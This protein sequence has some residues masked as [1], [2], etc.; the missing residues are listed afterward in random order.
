MPVSNSQGA[1]CGEHQADQAGFARAVGRLALLTLERG[2]GRDVDDDPSFTV[3][4]WVHVS[5]HQPGA[6]P[7]DV[8]GAHQIHIDDTL[9]LLDIERAVLAEHL[10]GVGNSSGVDANVDPAKCP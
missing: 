8:E 2:A 4:A 10:A 7:H 5:G 1:S 9:K 3:K 6:L